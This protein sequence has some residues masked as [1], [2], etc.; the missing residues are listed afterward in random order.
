MA[1]L[2]T[3]RVLRTLRYDPLHY[4]LFLQAG[5]IGGKTRPGHFAMLQAGE[6]LR[7]YLRR[8]F[9]IADVTTFGGVPALEFVV[10]VVGRGTELLGR[11]SEGTPIPVLGPLGQPFPVEDLA[12][13]D[14]V[15]LVAGGIGLAPLLLLSRWLSQAGVEA[16]LFYGGRNESDVL[17]RADF[18]RFLGPHRC[19]YATDDGSLGRRGRVTDLLEQSLGGGAKY[20]RVFACGPVPMFRTLSAILASAGIEGSF[21]LE[22]EMACGFG[23]CLGCVVPAAAGGYVTVCKEGPCLPADRIDWSRV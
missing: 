11:F 14:R 4:S 7:P 10:R 12:A 19:R 15:A 5:S 21:A 16:D 23:V 6:G 8:A 22:S 20:R 17:K 9:S 18:E 2:E 13:G 3:L 1:T